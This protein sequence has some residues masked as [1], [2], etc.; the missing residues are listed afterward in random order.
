M[1]GG[2]RLDGRIGLGRRGAARRDMVLRG[3]PL[4]ASTAGAG[5]ALRGQL[6][7]GEVGYKA[8]GGASIFRRTFS[9]TIGG[10]YG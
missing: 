2:P 6:F 8:S 4:L 7:Y 5:L 10:W 3:G 1:V 9:F